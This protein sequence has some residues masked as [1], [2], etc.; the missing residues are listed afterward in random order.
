[1]D[2]APSP[3]HS[4]PPGR[5]VGPY[6]LG[7]RIAAGAMGEVYRAHHGTTGE[8]AAI[9]VLAPEIPLREGVRLAREASAAGRVAHEGIVRILGHGGG[10]LPDEPAWLA[11]ELLDGETLDDRI[12]RTR[13][14]RTLLQAIEAM[15][16]PLAAAHAAGIVHR[17]LKPSNVFLARR[18]DGGERVVLIDFGIAKAADGAD[19]R[20][21]A[22]GIVLGTP[23][24]MSPEQ[25]RATREI[26]PETDVWSVGVMLYEALA[27]RVPFT[28]DS[29]TD[30]VVR[31]CTEEP[32]PLA[33]AVPGLDPEL[34]RIVHACLA[35]RPG[36]RPPDAGALAA[37]LAP[38]LGARGGG[39]TL[40]WGSTGPASHG[41]TERLDSGSLAGGT[42]AS[43][44]PATGR[45]GTPRRRPWLLV[46]GGMAVVIAGV[47][48][49]GLVVAFDGAPAAPFTSEDPTTQNASSPGVTT[50]SETG[51]AAVV[52]PAP[53]PASDLRP[54]SKDGRRE[55]Q[56]IDG[57]A[58]PAVELPEEPRALRR[59]RA[60]GARSSRRARPAD[61]A[62]PRTDAPSVAEL[63]RPL[64]LFASGDEPAPGADLPDPEEGSG[65]GPDPRAPALLP[66]P[67][68]PP[69]PAPTESPGSAPA[70]APA[71]R[72]HPSRS[73]PPPSAPSPGRE[74]SPEP[75]P[76]G[77][78]AP[79]RPPRR[80]PFTTF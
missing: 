58:G 70:Q 53:A 2:S 63:P 24:Y 44:A 46:G 18:P 49:G 28:G 71:P 35:K 66:A 9:K 31:V 29:V 47:V 13:D 60:D 16:P 17:D 73:S 59:A 42:G 57:P 69:P 3:R 80:P 11:M 76:A 33:A 25:A 55:P 37:A 75:D 14:R 6:V 43:A 51:E 61:D 41:A 26:G 78:E 21:T 39:A 56:G 22:T 8:P 45:R 15:L 52:A 40:P 65:G 27:G 67:P 4:F 10:E 36:D 72:E 20:L 30:V 62:A 32:P 64:G 23:F 74:V 68:P 38:V 77:D 48:A 5:R 79:A 7:D 50:G 54:P 34:A 19:P 12:R 1:M